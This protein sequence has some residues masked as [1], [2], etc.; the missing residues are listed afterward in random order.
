[1]PLPF[2]LALAPPTAPTKSI[3]V[4]SSSSPVMSEPEIFKHLNAKDRAHLTTVN[5]AIAEQSNMSTEQTYVTDVVPET[6]RGA[7]LIVGIASLPSSLTVFR[8][9]IA[10]LE[11]LC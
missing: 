7:E 8:Y 6:R 4:V 10:Q 3:G 9:V 1:M 11:L 2:A 5:R